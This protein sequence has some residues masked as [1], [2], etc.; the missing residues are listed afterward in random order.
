MMPPA[1]QDDRLWHFARPE[2][3]PRPSRRPLRGLLRMRLS[4]IGARQNYDRTLG[5]HPEGPPTAGVSKDGHRLLEP[6]FPQCLAR[7][8]LTHRARAALI[9]FNN[10]CSHSEHSAIG[11]KRAHNTASRAIRGNVTDASHPLRRKHARRLDD[12][13]LHRL[14][15]LAHAEAA[16]PDQRSV[17][18]RVARDAGRR[19]RRADDVRI[20][21]RQIHRRHGAGS[22]PVR[23]GRGLVR[24]RRLDRLPAVRPVDGEEAL[25]FRRIHHLG[26]DRAEIR[27][28]DHAHRVA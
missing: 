7:V 14:H 2:R 27:P 18:D 11:Q 15:L 24:A 3:A 22:V 9:D 23:H 28:V 6:G 21:R 10:I 16:Q 8:R 1:L 25:Q 19:R 20:R 13:R 12:R 4:G 26:R 5:P 17:H